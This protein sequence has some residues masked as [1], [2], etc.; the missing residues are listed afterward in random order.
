MESLGKS[1][2]TDDK[3]L[4]GTRIT[5]C[6][7]YTGEYNSE[8]VKETGRDVVFGG[9]SVDTRKLHIYGYIN[10]E[11]ENASIRIRLNDKALELNISEDGSFET[12][13][14]CTSGGNYIMVDYNNFSGKIKLNAEYEM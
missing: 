4:I 8:C 3:D 11:G 2:L 5:G 6:D 7:S 1:Q 9:S 10:G 13:L 14:N 12:H